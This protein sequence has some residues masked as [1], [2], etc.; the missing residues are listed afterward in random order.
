LRI[1][2]LAP[3]VEPDGAVIRA[4]E[5]RWSILQCSPRHRLCLLHLGRIGSRPILPRLLFQ[6]IGSTAQHFSVL[7]TKERNERQPPTLYLLKDVLFALG[8][9]HCKGNEWSSRQSNL[10]HRQH[11]SAGT[12]G[13][14]KRAVWPMIIDGGRCL[15]G[16]PR[17]CVGRSARSSA[18]GES[19]SWL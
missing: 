6:L 16:S 5:V 17:Y 9:Q 4:L 12:S 15:W 19:A 2:A 7:D 14:V 10:A 11:D 13:V 3:H 18:S 1:L 8:R